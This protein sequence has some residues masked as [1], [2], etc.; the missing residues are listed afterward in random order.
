MAHAQAQIIVAH[1][2]RAADVLVLRIASFLK[3]A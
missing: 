3:P 2:L 1:T